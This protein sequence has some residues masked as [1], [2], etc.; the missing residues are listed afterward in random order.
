MK[1]HSHSMEPTSRRTDVWLTIDFG[2]REGRVA[3]G[4]L[5]DGS[6]LLEGVVRR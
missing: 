3:V 4:D 6:I 2:R 5:G 1:R